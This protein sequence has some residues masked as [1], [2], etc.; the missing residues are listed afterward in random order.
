MLRVGVRTAP[1]VIVSIQGS[2]SPASPFWP[3]LASEQQETVVPVSH[4]F[5]L[6]EVSASFEALNIDVER[7][8]NVVH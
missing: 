4:V 1:L 3:V 7:K 6:L 2:S 8:P 5:S